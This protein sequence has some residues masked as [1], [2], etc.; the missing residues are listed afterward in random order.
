MKNN[1]KQTAT[2]TENPNVLAKKYVDEN[3]KFLGLTKNEER[4]KIYY[5]GN[6]DMAPIALRQPGDAFY[7]PNSYTKKLF[8]SFKTQRAGDLVGKLFYEDDEPID[9]Y[10]TRDQYYDPANTNLN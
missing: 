6:P 4:V 2:V 3:D 9:E 7:N 1:F 8:N 10:Y 5:Q